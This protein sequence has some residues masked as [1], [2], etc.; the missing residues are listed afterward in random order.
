M[1]K[2]TDAIS[3]ENPKD[4]FLNRVR[5][6]INLPTRV[7]SAASVYTY[8]VFWAD[9]IKEDEISRRGRRYFFIM[10]KTEKESIGL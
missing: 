10:A 3:T 8:S 1:D 5:S 2:L 6:G 4:G 7:S 9:T